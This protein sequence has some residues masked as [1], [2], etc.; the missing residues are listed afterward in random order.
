MSDG[1]ARL[2]PTIESTARRLVLL[3]VISGTC[4]F[5]TY[6][7]DRSNDCRGQAAGEATIL[8]LA[9]I[10]F[11]VSTVWL[12]TSAIQVLAA[13]A[14]RGDAWLRAGRTAALAPLA[15]IGVS[16]VLW[17]SLPGVD[18]SVRLVIAL[19]LWIFAVAHGLGWAP[20][21]DG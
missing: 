9:S 14:T 11:T 6:V 5:V 15:Y 18:R 2:A 10:V 17:S 8:A 16:A 4:L 21:C 7:A 20:V 3:A 19:G 12:L 13:A 1:Y